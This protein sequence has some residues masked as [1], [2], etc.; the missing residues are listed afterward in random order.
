MS[1]TK[2]V[3]DT[4]YSS[5]NQSSNKIEVNFEHVLWREREIQMENEIEIVSHRWYS[6]MD[7]RVVY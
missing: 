6:Y 2:V 5:I 3:V 1:N 4:T 7:Q